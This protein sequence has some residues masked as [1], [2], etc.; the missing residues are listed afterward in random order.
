MNHAAV[1]LEIPVTAVKSRVYYA[2][3]ALRIVMAEHTGER[4]TPPE[5]EASPESDVDEPEA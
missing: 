5:R 1:A 4:V 2:L 3:R